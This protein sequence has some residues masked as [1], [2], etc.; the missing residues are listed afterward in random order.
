VTLSWQAVGSAKWKWQQKKVTI[1]WRYG[2]VSGG[3]VTAAVRH[4]CGMQWVVQSGSG[5]KKGKKVTI[6]Q[7]CGSVSGGVG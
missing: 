5:G 6:N 3:V 2:S 7:R 4:R 1:N